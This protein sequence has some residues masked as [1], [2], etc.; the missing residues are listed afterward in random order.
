MSANGYDA[1]GTELDPSTM[2]TSARTPRL[3]KEGKD[4][5]AKYVYKGPPLRGHLRIAKRKDTG[6]EKT[7]E[8][9][10]VVR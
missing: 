2:P 9:M 7:L 10:L 4:V 6:K 5:S 8:Q 1:G 3:F